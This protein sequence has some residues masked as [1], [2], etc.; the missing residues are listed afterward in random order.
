MTVFD[1]RFPTF[2]DLALR[3]KQR[4]P[5]FAFDYV[6]SGVGEERALYRNREA[7]DSILLRQCT[8][9]DVSTIDTTVDLFGHRYSYP[10]GVAPMGA[11][12]IIWPR[13]ESALATAACK[14]NIPYI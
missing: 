13:A 4:I 9:L 8:M 11:G 7:W 6:D 10:F 2:H 14:A 3:A 1:Q 12:N 5:R